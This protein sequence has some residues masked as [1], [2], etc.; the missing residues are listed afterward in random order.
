MPTSSQYLLL[1]LF[2]SLVNSRSSNSDVK[3]RQRHNNPIECTQMRRL[4]H[5]GDRSL[6]FAYFL[7]YNK[8]NKLCAWPST[9]TVSGGRVFFKVKTIRI[10][11]HFVFLVPPL[12]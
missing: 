2:E 6:K 4:V 11:A 5:S 3:S 9:A 1:L 12:L 7:L 10:A 8:L